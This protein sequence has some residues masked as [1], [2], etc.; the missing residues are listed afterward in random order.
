M[1]IWCDGYDIVNYR[2]GRQLEQRHAAT[3]VFEKAV[4]AN[5]NAAA[6]AGSG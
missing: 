1:K 2:L 6:R 5:R 3:R 4:K